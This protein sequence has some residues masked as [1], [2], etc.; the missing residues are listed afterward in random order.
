MNRWSI[1]RTLC[2]AAAALMLCCAAG[3]GSD[4]P[5]INDFNSGYYTEQSTVEQESAVTGFTLNHAIDAGYGMGTDT[6]DVIRGRFGEPTDVSTQEYTKLTIVTAAYPFGEFVFNGTDGGTPVLT[7]VTINQQ[8]AAPFGIA[9]GA[10]M[11]TALDAVCAGSFAQL[12]GSFEKNLTFYGDGYSA[13]S[14]SYTW[15]TA[16]FTS[17]TSTAKYSAAYIADGY[18]PGSTV[19]F[20]MYFN[21]EGQLVYYTLGYHS[22]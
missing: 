5:V 12:G 14:G 17:T 2:C 4:E 7:T 10:D 18:E 3:C 20:T 16:E 9:V 6:L 8:Y 19:K 13:P 22:A 11:Q 15:L 21:G 1:R